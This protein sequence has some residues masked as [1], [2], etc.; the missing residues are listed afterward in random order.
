MSAY[1]KNTNWSV[2]MLLLVTFVYNLINFGFMV[3]VVFQYI[4]LAS[5]EGLVKQ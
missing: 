1:I 2:G 4:C 5:S 3:F